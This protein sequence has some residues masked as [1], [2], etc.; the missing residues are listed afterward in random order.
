MKQH[1]KDPEPIKTQKRKKKILKI[2]KKER[3]KEKGSHATIQST[4]ISMTENIQHCQGPK[5]KHKKRISN[6]L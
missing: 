4:L 6:N 1:I 5:R 3:K 2:N